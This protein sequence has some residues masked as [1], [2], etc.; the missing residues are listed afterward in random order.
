M[1]WAVGSGMIGG[2]KKDGKSYLNPKG[3]A[4]RAESATMLM[5]FIEKY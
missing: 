2:S 5:R 3:K 1:K 4:T